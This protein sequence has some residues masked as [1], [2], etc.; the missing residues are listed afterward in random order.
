MNTLQKCCTGRGV[1]RAKVNRE[2]RLAPHS[3]IGPNNSSP[4]VVAV[5]TDVVRRN[6][7]WRRGWRVEGVNL[8]VGLI[9]RFGAEGA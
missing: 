9:G 8:V 2:I 7:D 6:I 1:R 3:A 5:G 4:A